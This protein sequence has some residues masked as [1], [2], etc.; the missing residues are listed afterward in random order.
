MHVA[1]ESSSVDAQ[2]ASIAIVKQ[3]TGSSLVGSG[4]G[5]RSEVGIASV[6][7]ES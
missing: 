4:S 5:A 6:L 1:D 7:I 2:V 3:A